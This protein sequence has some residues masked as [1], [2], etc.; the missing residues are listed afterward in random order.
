[1][2]D[3][4]AGSVSV[5]IGAAAVIALCGVRLAAC[6]DRLADKTGWGEALMGGLFLAGVTSAPDFAATLTAA[7]HGYAELAMGNILGSMAANLV[8]LAVGDLTYRN[9]NLEHA[10]ASSGNLIQATLFITLMT[11]PLLGMLTPSFAVMAVHPATPVLLLAYLF[12]YHLVR[13]D[14]DKPMWKPQ[15]TAQTVIDQPRRRRSREDSLPDLWLQFASLA[16]LTAVAG[17]LLMIAAESLVESTSL[18]QT[19]VGTLFT[20][21]FT[22]LPELVTTL[23][24]IRFGALTLAVGNILGTNCFNVMVIAAADLAFRGGS[25]YHAVGSQQLVW[26]ALSILLTAI[27]LLGLL[28]RE[29]YGIA[30]IGFESFLVLLVYVGAAMGIML[31]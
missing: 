28:R 8:F 27:L 9:A 11:I 15:R 20:A 2:L 18:S 29:R 17:W 10:A 31:M 30:R 1:M 6:A 22:S 5:L 7:A 26:S 25:I 12:G 16:L 14:L 3:T 21:V 19:L 4:L 24:A 13:R 23:A